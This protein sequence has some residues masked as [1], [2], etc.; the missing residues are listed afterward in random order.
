MTGAA[1]TSKRRSDS[2]QRSTWRENF[3]EPLSMSTLDEATSMRGFSPLYSTRIDPG[4][5]GF[6]GGA[7]I[8]G[9]RAMRP[10]SE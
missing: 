4:S 1:A 8:E 5:C 7:V 9:G 10:D 3:T 6:A 2:F